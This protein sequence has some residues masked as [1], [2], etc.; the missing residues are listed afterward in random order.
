MSGR[1]PTAS[2]TASTPVSRMVLSRLLRLAPKQETLSLSDEAR[3]YKALE[4]NV[5]PWS[6][7]SKNARFQLN[8]YLLD[9]TALGN[10]ASSLRRFDS[11]WKK[12]PPLTNNV[13]TLR[14]RITECMAVNSKPQPG[15]EMVPLYVPNTVIEAI[16]TGGSIADGLMTCLTL[17]SATGIAGLLHVIA[18][19]SGTKCKQ[20]LNVLLDTETQA[21]G[22]IEGKSSVLNIDKQWQT[23]VNRCTGI[24]TP[25]ALASSSVSSFVKKLLD[26]MTQA[27]DVFLGSF[28][29]SEKQ[30]T[31]KVES[32]W[33]PGKDAL[34]Q[35]EYF[36]AALAMV[37]HDGADYAEKVCDFIQKG[38]ALKQYEPWGA[39]SNGEQTEL[40]AEEKGEITDPTDTLSGK[41][42]QHNNGKA[43]CKILTLAHI[44]GRRKVSQEPPAPQTSI[45]S[46]VEMVEY[47]GQEHKKHPNFK[48]ILQD[49]VDWNEKSGW[50]DP[51]EDPNITVT[52]QTQSGDVT[53]APTIH[54][55]SGAGI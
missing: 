31:F 2:P 11:Q 44:P 28:T 47:L 23:L 33:H 32:S 19:C 36:Q 22:P 6:P 46:L 8:S 37:T 20:Q 13:S 53:P 17:Q 45:Q 9:P 49:L 3:L 48:K 24:A 27:H 18:T 40:S 52:S 55:T 39:E 26:R 54:T 29:A 4:G 15:S 35:G 34:M 30:W 1:P 21:D 41:G 16:S 38:E 10:A 42:R 14:G 7:S 5:W 50:S 25:E 12:L 51:T 43:K